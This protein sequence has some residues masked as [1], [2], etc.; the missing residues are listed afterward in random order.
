M[1]RAL[2]PK[3]AKRAVWPDDKTGRSALDELPT[4]KLLRMVVGPF[5]GRKRPRSRAAREKGAASWT[6]YIRI[7][8]RFEDMCV[9]KTKAIWGIDYIHMA[10]WNGEWKII[11]VLWRFVPEREG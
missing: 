3:L 11:N 1:K 2:H 6:G 9:V 4:P 10:K 8:D 5:F 7:L